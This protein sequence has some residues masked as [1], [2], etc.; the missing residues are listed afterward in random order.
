MLPDLPPE[1]QPAVADFLDVQHLCVWRALHRATLHGLY[2]LDLTYVTRRLQATEKRLRRRDGLFALK[3]RPPGGIKVA[4]RALWMIDAAEDWAR[5]VPHLAVLQLLRRGARGGEPVVLGEGSFDAQLV[6]LPAA[7]REWMMLTANVAVDGVP[8]QLSGGLIY[9]FMQQ[10]HEA[11][12]PC[13]LDAACAIYGGNAGC[14]EDPPMPSSTDWLLFRSFTSLV[15]FRL[16]QAATGSRPSPSLRRIAEWTAWS[17]PLP[18]AQQ[19]D[20]LLADSSGVW[21]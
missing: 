19:V 15:F 17:P 5:W 6:P 3:I 20:R 18:L 10:R 11:V 4:L 14:V 1:A 7:I 2:P 21:V 16:V 9:N 12:K 13:P 8:L